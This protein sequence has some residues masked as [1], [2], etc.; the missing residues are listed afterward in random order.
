MGKVTIYA[1]YY[2][3]TED[4]DGFEY[5]ITRHTLFEDISVME[6]GEILSKFVPDSS[7][8]EFEGIFIS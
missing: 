8:G 5:G 2:D 6:I 1:E 3:P 7:Y 4:D